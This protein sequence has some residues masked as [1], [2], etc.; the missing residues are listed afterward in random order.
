MFIV[1]A[2]PKPT[3]FNS[4]LKDRAVEVLSGA[5]H[6]IAVTDL[7]AESFDPRGGRHDFL[8][9][10]MDHLLAVTSETNALTAG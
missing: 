7:Y 3:P 1:Y 2:H 10:W 5:G 6:D 4:A 8:D 9:P